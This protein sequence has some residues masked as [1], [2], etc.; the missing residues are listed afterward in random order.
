MDINGSVIKEPPVYTSPGTDYVLYFASV[1][2]DIPAW[3]SSPI[4]RDRK[5]R[6]FWP[7]EPILAGSLFSISSRYAGFQWVLKGP[8]RQVGISKRVFRNSEQGKGWTTLILKTLIDLF[9]QDN[10]AFIEIVR[11][12]NSPTAPCIQLNHLDAGRC[13]RTGRS[14]EPVV[15]YDRV[16]TPHYLKWYQVFTLEEFPSPIESMYS[17]QY[18]AISRLLRAAQILRDISVYKR[19][20]IGGR[21]NRAIHLVSGIHQKTLNDA[22]MK[23]QQDADA[24]GLIRYVNPVVIGSLDPTANVNVATIELASLPDAFNEETAMKWYVNQLA[25][26]FGGDYQDFAPLPAGNLGTSEQSETLH[27]KSRGK[28]SRLFMHMMENA[29]N[30]YGIIPSTV[31]FSYGEQDIAET[32]ETAQLRKLRAEERKIR[33]ESGEITPQIAR[34]LA[35]DSGDLDERYVQSLGE[36]NLTDETKVKL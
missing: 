18:C 6:E 1:A 34:Q 4:D 20:K 8:E 2:D 35:Q 12:D 24:Q 27:L 22:I 13:I 21:F 16:G 36:E 26:A 28:G 17:V 32:L 25:L 29:I 11:T 5:L 10:G 30:T 31:E 23:K 33:I 19:E 3:G 15:Y 14:E 7:T 9:S